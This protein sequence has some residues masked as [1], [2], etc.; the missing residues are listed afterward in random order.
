[1]INPIK[2]WRLNQGYDQLTMANLLTISR[3][4]VSNIETNKAIPNGLVLL[5][6]LILTKI[7]IKVLYSYYVNLK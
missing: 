3:Q 5:Q 4:H 7:D 6:I 2:L 1:M